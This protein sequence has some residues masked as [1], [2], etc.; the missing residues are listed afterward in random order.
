MGDDEKMTL[1]PVDP[2][3]HIEKKELFLMTFNFFYIT[4]Q[5]IPMP[6]SIGESD[7]AALMSKR[8]QKMDFTHI[9]K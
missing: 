5:P 8:H 1:T 6:I 7:L 4:T 2:F 9:S 3:L